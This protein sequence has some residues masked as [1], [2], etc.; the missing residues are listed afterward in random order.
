MLCVG[1]RH[2][3]HHFAIQRKIVAVS[4]TLC[5]YHDI[6]TRCHLALPLSYRYESSRMLCVGSRHRSHHFA[7]QQKIVAAEYIP[8]DTLCAYHDISTR[9]HLALPLSYR[10]ESSKKNKSHVIRFTNLHLALPLSYRYES[11]KKFTNLPVCI[12]PRQSNNLGRGPMVPTCGL[13]VGRKKW[14]CIRS[15]FVIECT[16]S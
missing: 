8:S 14:Y 7:I 11:G 5:A 1:S 9:C 6:S 15:C 10:Y 13:V 12:P 4:D 2:R 3:S 16:Y